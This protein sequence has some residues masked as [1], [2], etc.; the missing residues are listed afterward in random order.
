MPKAPPTFTPPGRSRAEQRRA[1]DAD[2]DKNKP[3]RS[4]YKSARWRDLRDAQLAGEPLCRMCLEVGR[5]T[6]ATVCDHVTPHEENEAAFWAGPF[7]SLCAPCHSSTKQRDERGTR[8]AFRPDWLKPSL[9]PVTLVFGPPCSGKTA[10]IA[11]SSATGDLTVDLDLIA[12][13]LACSSVHTWDRTWLGPAIRRRNDLV[14]RLSKPP[15]PWPTAWIIMSGATSEERLWW[16]DKLH[17]RRTVIIE[18]PEEICQQRLE[19]DP[20][21]APRRD[22]I[23]AAIRD[24]WRRYDRYMGEERVIPAT[25]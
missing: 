24:W 16:R 2:R 5:V 10:W 18:T 23:A 3:S 25:D 8:F 11:R 15:V 12:S 4:W 14:G 1:Y 6:A 21:R 19:R 13:S 22:D 9:I 7:Q 20:E 17:A